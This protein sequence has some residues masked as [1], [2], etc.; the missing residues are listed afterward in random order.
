MNDVFNRDKEPWIRPWNKEKFNDLYN[1][2]ERFFAI[3]VKGFL[4][5]LNRNIVL[6]NESIKHFIF[7]T[8]SSYLYMESNGYEYNLSETTG[9][10]T[11]Y[12]SLPRCLIELSDVNI[13][14]EELSAPFSRGDYERVSGNQLQ[15][16]NAE[17]RRLPIELTI[18]MKYYLSNF[19]ETLILL[20]ELIDKLVFQRYFNI[21]YLGK[22]IQCSIEFP[23][24][25]NPQ[26]NKIDMTSP[27]PNQ[28][29]LTF[30]VKIS[31]N[32][33]IIDE[34]TEIP[35]DKVIS[36]F[37]Y[38]ADTY[39]HNTKTDTIH[40]GVIF[41]GNDGYNEFENNLI[42]ENEDIAFKTVNKDTDLD[43][44]NVKDK[45]IKEFDINN[46]NI[47]DLED[48][49]K[50][51]DDNNDGVIDEHELTN[52]LE[53]IKYENY[54]KKHD[55]IE[56]CHY[57][58]DYKDLYYAIMLVNKQENISAHYDKLTNKIYVTHNDTG[59]THEIDMIK[60]KVIN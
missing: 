54:D 30:D 36:N 56:D 58:I 13:P 44:T 9:E 46:D 50:R 29:N 25:Y 60:Y 52:I 6:Y 21:T 19:N 5:W 31:T 45:F 42:K 51:F 32:Y 1:R 7:N 3:V 8:G 38:K 53:R 43:I 22:I 27:D 41:D 47:I 2:D 37:G 4:S 59:D 18:N 55:Y 49:I 14:L 20:Q 10:D 39:L 57:R 48:L 11:I 26:I 12:M 16:F 28:R 34:R 17:I 23:G 15:G 35:T 24:S 33:P 40:T